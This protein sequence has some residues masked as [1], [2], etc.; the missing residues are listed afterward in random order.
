MRQRIIGSEMVPPPRTAVLPS[1]DAK[2]FFGF[3]VKYLGHEI[4]DGSTSRV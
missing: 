2:N 1:S 4:G 3:A